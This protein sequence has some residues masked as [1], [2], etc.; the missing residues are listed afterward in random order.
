MIVHAFVGFF[1]HNYS[2]KH[3]KQMLDPWSADRAGRAVQFKD[4]FKK[5]N[6]Q[7]ISRRGQNAGGTMKSQGKNAGIKVQ[8][9]T[10]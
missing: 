1:G 4:L 6:S 10:R 8:H 9:R 3:E 5:A 2:K 7:V